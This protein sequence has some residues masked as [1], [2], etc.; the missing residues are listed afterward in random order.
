MKNDLIENIFQT[1]RAAL[2]QDLEL[3]N[4]A[5][6]DEDLLTVHQ[7]L[8]AKK[9]FNPLKDS[10]QPIL[11]LTPYVHI[12]FKETQHVHQKYLEIEISKKHYF[13]QQNINFEKIKGLTINN[14]IS[15]RQQH[16]IDSILK[17][18]LTSYQQKKSLFLYGELDTGKTFFFKL[19]MKHFLNHQ[20]N[21]LFIFMPDFIRQ[22]KLNWYDETTEK[23]M[24]ILS[25]VEVLL[26]D[27]FG[28]GTMTE[29]FRNDILLSLL[30]TRHHNNLPIIINTSLNQEEGRQRGLIKSRL[31]NCNA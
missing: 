18:Y 23:K 1:I 12:V 15:Y 31:T 3:K 4:Y 28:F 6:D 8:K 24:K 5:F 11:K 9:D 22:F 26:L 21:F 30:E 2:Q 19:L 20:K 17:N 27:D 14:L 25:E 29:Y 16:N 10:Y 7:Y 13:F